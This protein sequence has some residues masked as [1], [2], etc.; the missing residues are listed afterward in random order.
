MPVQAQ[1]SSPGVEIA[2]SPL[3]PHASIPNA[4]DLEEDFYELLHFFP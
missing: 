1:E 2:P 4:V 3:D